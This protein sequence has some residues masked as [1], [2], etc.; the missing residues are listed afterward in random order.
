VWD[1][2][3]GAPRRRV[4]SVASEHLVGGSPASI[5]AAVCADGKTIVSA[6]WERIESKS[7][8]KVRRWDRDTGRELSTWSRELSPQGLGNADRPVEALVISPDG[9]TVAAPALRL[10]P[11]PMHLWE[12]A[13]GK[14]LPGIAGSY[15]AFSP[16]GR[17]VATAPLQLKESGPSF[18][19]WEVATAT[20]LCSVPIEG[21]VHGLLFSPDGRMLATASR[22]LTNLGLSQPST[23]HLW[24]LLKDESQKAG[25]RLGPARLVPGDV[26]PHWSGAWAF[27]P[28]GRTLALAGEGGTVRL[29]ESATG[30]ERARFAGHGG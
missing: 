29:L 13:T 2:A 8:I 24:P 5:T 18:S 12:A 11:S 10:D 1:T 30:Q 25:V 20:E 23:L 6:A 19:L 4:L 16:T 7:Y 27:S 15:L 26:S 9:K 17:F 21:R 14:E 28:D 22:K 3:T